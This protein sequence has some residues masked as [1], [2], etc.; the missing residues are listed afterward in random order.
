MPT[1]VAVR[2]A[3]RNSASLSLWRRAQAT[4]KP[5]T[6]GSITPMMATSVAETFCEFAADLGRCD[7][8]YQEHQCMTGFDV[9]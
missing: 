8:R 9:C 1:L 2:S 4:P 5:A 6:R 7:D 3:P